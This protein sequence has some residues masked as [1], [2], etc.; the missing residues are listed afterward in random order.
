[1]T[2]WGSDIDVRD[3]AEARSEGVNHTLLDV[4]EAE[5]VAVCTIPDSLYISMRQVP[6]HLDELPRQHPLVVMCHHGG[7]SHM[8]AEFLRGNGFTNVHN[9]AGGI[10]DWAQ[11]I[12]REMP[13]Y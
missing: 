11:T 10:D 12:D 9:L 1:M 4:R 5:E 3:L 13:R 7:R 6:A 8:V 2:R